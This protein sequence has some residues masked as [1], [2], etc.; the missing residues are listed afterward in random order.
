[1]WRGHGAAVGA[2]CDLERTHNKD[3]LIASGSS[4]RSIRVW[5]GDTGECL[6]VLQGH[7]EQVRSIVALQEGGIAAGGHD[8]TIRIWHID[9]KDEEYGRQLLEGHGDSVCHLQLQSDGSI[10][11]ASTDGTVRLWK[12]PLDRTGVVAPVKRS[13]ENG[14]ESNNRDRAQ[15]AKGWIHSFLQLEAEKAKYLGIG[16]LNT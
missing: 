5:H 11:S 14:K 10:L 13:S 4:D 2:L 12:Y 15:R 7:R 1:M 3:P 9:S 16:N 8:G 6:R